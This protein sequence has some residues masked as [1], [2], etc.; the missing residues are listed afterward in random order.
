MVLSQ[1]PTET[2]EGFLASLKC[3]LLRTN[4]MTQEETFWSG[5][6]E[7]LSALRNVPPVLKIVWESGPWVVSLGL[8]L[9]LLTSLV[10]I[11]AL[12]ITKLIIDDI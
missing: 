10:P 1:R 3:S 11:A 12:W 7:R 4:P 6:R 8:F 5:W 2:P 9:R